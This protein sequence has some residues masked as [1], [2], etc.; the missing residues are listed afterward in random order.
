MPL[1]AALIPIGT[2]LMS[3]VKGAGTATAISQ[4]SDLTKKIVD[5]GTKQSIGDISG[6]TIESPRTGGATT[7]SNKEAEQ[8]MLDLTKK[9]TGYLERFAK[10]GIQTFM[11][12]NP[13]GSKF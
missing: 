1:P 12:P 13:E 5:V 3:A 10:K 7:Q 9:S 8:L 6:G 11:P 4:T 2:A